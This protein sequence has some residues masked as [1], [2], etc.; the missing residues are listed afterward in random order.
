[1]NR[2]PKCQEPVLDVAVNCRKCG[3]P[4]DEKTFFLSEDSLLQEVREAAKEAEQKIARQRN[5]RKVAQ[6][7]LVIGLCIL[8]VGVGFLLREALPMWVAL[9]G[10]AV[11]GVG[12]VLLGLSRRST[13]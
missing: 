12:A 8:G 10:L 4:I 2:C 3:E 6:I 9:G 1:M 13:D 5:R 11:T 7:V